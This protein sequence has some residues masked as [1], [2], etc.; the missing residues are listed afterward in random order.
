MAQTSATVSGVIARIEVSADLTI[1]RNISGS[2]QSV[3]STDQERATNEAYTLDGDTAIIA[4]GKRQP[5]DLEFNIVYSDTSTE[6]YEVARAIFESGDTGS[7]VYVR[8]VP[9]GGADV[10]SPMY[11]TPITGSPAFITMFRYP[12]VDAAAPGPIMGM[13]RVRTPFVQKTTAGNTTG[14]S[15]T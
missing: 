1:W 8:W 10:A 13:F 6:A 15:G 9:T 5:I 3:Q 4:T 12:A 7:K 11:R 14:G 2:A